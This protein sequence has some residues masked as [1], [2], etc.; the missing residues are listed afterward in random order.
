MAQSEELARLRIRDRLF[1]LL[2]VLDRH[3]ELEVLIFERSPFAGMEGSRDLIDQTRAQHRDI[4]CLRADILGALE[5]DDDCPFP[6][7]SD[8]TKVL[9][10]SLRWHL[11]SEENTLWPHYR[12]CVSRSLDQTLTSQLH[13]DIEIIEEDLTRGAVSLHDGRY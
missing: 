10:D 2:P 4:A 11:D 5:F 7:L 9:I 12:A 3:E 1:L 13:R 6:V 8:L